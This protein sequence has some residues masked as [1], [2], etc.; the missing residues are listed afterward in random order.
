MV[1]ASRLSLPLG[2]EFDRRTVAEGIS[3]RGHEDLFLRRTH[4]Y[5]VRE[6]QQGAAPVT[7]ASRRHASVAP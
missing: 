6:R 7:T 1:F 5:A 4:R 3:E 2:A